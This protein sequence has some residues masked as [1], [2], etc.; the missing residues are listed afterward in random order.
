MVE[1][2]R[3]KIKKFGAENKNLNAGINRSSTSL[4][5]NPIIRVPKSLK[6]KHNF[7]VLTERIMIPYLRI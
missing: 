2:K 5:S 6:K 1:K 4:R 3:G 7:C